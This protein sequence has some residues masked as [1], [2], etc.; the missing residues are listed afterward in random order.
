MYKKR[1]GGHRWR[2]LSNSPRF[3]NAVWNRCSLCFCL[4][5]H[6]RYYQLIDLSLAY[7]A[8]STGFRAKEKLL[9]AYHVMEALFTLKVSCGETLAFLAFEYS[10]SDINLLWTFLQP[11]CDVETS[12]SWAVKHSKS[13]IYWYEKWTHRFNTSFSSMM[14]A[15]QPWSQA[16]SAT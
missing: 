8:L 12:P 1:Q 7:R 3:R 5:W 11:S 15:T 9:A 14:P 16:L 13:K 2:E 6:P 10:K 4:F